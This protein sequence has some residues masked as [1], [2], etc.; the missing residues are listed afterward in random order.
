MRLGRDGF[1]EA[2]TRLN[3]STLRKRGRS[4]EFEASQP[5]PNDR[6]QAVAA[7]RRRLRAAYLRE[8]L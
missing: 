1:F 7:R 4:S 2:A 5:F 6:H 3:Q 8:A